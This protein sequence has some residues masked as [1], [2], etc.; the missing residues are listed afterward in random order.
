MARAQRL[1]HI[2]MSA[3]SCL[4]HFHELLEYGCSVGLG[5]RSRL[6][7]VPV[8]Q[9]PHMLLVVVMGFLIC[10][11]DDDAVTLSHTRARMNGHVCTDFLDECG[12]RTLH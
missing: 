2:L 6:W 11:F 3:Q 4:S 12:Y 7:V 1:L 8:L 10:T 9:S 5:L